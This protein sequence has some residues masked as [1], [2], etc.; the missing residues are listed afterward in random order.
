[1]SPLAALVSD[2]DLPALRRLFGLYDEH[3]RVWRVA[4]EHRLLQGSQNQLVLNPLYRQA[5]GLRA[6][7]LALEDRFGLTPMARL[8]LGATFGDARRSLA[9]E[10]QAEASA[11]DDDYEDEDAATVIDIGPVSL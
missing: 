2:A 3:D 5:S 1:M 6:D 4:R 11:S 7:I 9:D 10:L 8:K